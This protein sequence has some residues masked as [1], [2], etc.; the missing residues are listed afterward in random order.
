MPVYGCALGLSFHR[1]GRV[2]KKTPRLGD[3]FR[4]AAAL[5]RRFRRQRGD[6]AAGTG[7]IQ[8]DE[9]ALVGFTADEAPERLLEAKSGQQIV[10]ALAEAGASRFVQNCGFRPRHLIEDAKP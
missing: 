10:I 3:G 5:H 4:K 9:Y 1:Q 8:D 6:E 7:A 2:Y